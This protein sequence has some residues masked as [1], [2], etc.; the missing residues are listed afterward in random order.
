MLGGS[1]TKGDVVIGITHGLR[2]NAV[3]RALEIAYSCGS[4]RCTWRQFEARVA[5]LAGVFS[6]LGVARGERIALLSSNTDAFYES[7]LAAPWA[8]AIFASFNTRWAAKEI[9][10]AAQDCEPVLLIADGANYAAARHLQKSCPSIKTVLWADRAPGPGAAVCL[11]ALMN[12]ADPIPDASPGHEECFALFY[13][14]GTTS[15]AKGVMVSSAACQLLALSSLSTLAVRESSVLLHCGPLFHM[16][17]AGLVFIQLMAG[18]RGVILPRFDPSEVISNIES[19]Q[20]T[21]IALVPSMLRM[22]LEVETFSAARLGSLRR[23]I[24]G[25]S[26][27]DEPLLRSAMDALPQ[28]KFSQSYGMTETCAMGASLT[29]QDHREASVQGGRLR[30]VGRAIPGVELQIVGPEGARLGPGEAGEIC[31][32]GPVCLGYWRRSEAT[33]RSLRDGWFHTGDG[34]W[35][36]QDG[37]L[38]LTDRLKDMIISGGENVYSNEVE[39]VLRTYPGVVECAVIGTPDPLW[40]E[41]VT[42]IVRLQV[43]CSVTEQDV[44]AHCRRSLGGY[45]VPKRVF[46]RVEPLP[47]TALGKV[48]K[49][50]LREEYGAAAP[51]QV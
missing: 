5:R 51:Q 12:A 20:V 19:E 29:P 8:G 6:N 42:A 31:V 37:Y 14:G 2:R 48:Q 23:I 35:I 26:P 18:A 16:A 10:A 13:T 1:G 30:S 38:Y 25:G 44:I 36:D 15:C 22:L 43:G 17:A 33:A 46:L 7:L 41:L 49:A 39:S 34:G 4:H 21:H 9:E 50:V 32:K 47:V 27:M 45:K 3:S 40:G 24:Y 28:V 11:Q